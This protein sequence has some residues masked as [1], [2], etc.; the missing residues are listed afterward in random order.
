[1]FLHRARATR[2]V[3]AFLLVMVTLVVVPRADI[4]ETLFD[5]ATTPI[6]E[7]GVVEKAVSSW[8]HRQSVTAF[9]P[10][11]FAQPRKTP[12]RKILQV[13]AAQLTDSRTFRELFC[14][15]LC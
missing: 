8:E 12:V 4:P 11:I 2:L 7:T 9:V 6:N 10:R 15:L 13:Y 3:T 1:M 14:S 5:E